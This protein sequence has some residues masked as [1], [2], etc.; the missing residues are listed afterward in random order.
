MYT[1]AGQRKKMH[2]PE[3]AIFE[4][5]STMQNE[6]DDDTRTAVAVSKNLLLHTIQ[7]YLF[8]TCTHVAAV[9]FCKATSSSEGPCIVSRAAYCSTW[10]YISTVVSPNL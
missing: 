9:I 5:N 8:S 1:P 7:F 2:G 10:A 3:R 6:S 4:S